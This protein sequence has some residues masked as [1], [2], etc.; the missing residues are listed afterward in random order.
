MNPASTRRRCLFLCLIFVIGLSGL[1]ARLVYLQVVKSS[2]Y[3]KKSDRV[4]VRKELLKA[5]RGCI[6]DINNQLVARNIPRARLALDKKLLHDIGP[7]TLAL[8]NKELRETPEWHDWDE[9]TRKRQIKA[10]ASKMK[11]EMQ[12]DVIIDKYIAHVINTFARPLGLHPL[13]LRERMNLDNK[14]QKY[15]VL[16][17]DISED[18]ADKLK[19]LTIDHSILHAFVFEETQKR[20]YVM[21]EMAAH[22]IGFVSHESKGMAGIESQMDSYMAGKDGYVKNHRDKF[23]LLAVAKPQEIRPPIHGL[24]VQLTI[25]MGLQAILEEELDAGLAEFQAIKGTIIL[26]NPKTG[27]VMAMASRPTYNLNTRENIAENGYDFATQ[28]IYEPGSTLKIISTAGAMDLGLVLPSTLVNCHYGNYRVGSVRVPDHHPYGMLSVEQVLAKSSNI[29][30][31]K[32]AL[33]LGRERFFDYLADFGFGK[34]TGIRM[35]GESAGVTNDTGNPTDFSRNSYG[36]A[37]SVTPL[38]VACAYSAIANG[39]TLMKP[40]LVKSIM[41]NNGTTIMNNKPIPVRRVIKESTA[42]KMRRALA[43][44]VDIKGTAS[45]AHVDGFQVG[46][47]T[48]TTVKINPDG[49]YLHG[50]YTVSFAGMLP[51]EDPAF[52]CVVVVDDPQTNEVKRYGG[53]IAAPIFAKVATRVANRLGLEPTEPIAP[54]QPLAQ[55]DH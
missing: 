46:G 31:Y 49:G 16:K 8:A 18:D 48:G 34:K 14:K 13:E 33:Q 43:T 21:P 50:R 36:Y 54:S 24:N 30:S 28:A 19:Q 26:M 17:Q 51:A 12:A 20:W 7:A 3:A 32:I 15:V 25:D 45:R 47:K 6:V 27:E 55:S 35:A 10:R 29:G 2:D 4:S 41:A 5:N 37:I 53:T 22:I 1:S 42:R 38:Q 52:V 9:R 44:V 11:N 40:L 39:G 23:D